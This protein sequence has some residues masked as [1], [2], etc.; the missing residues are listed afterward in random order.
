MQN[1]HI[2]MNYYTSTSLVTCRNMSFYNNPYYHSNKV[3][4]S[5]LGIWPYQSRLWSYVN[6]AITLFFICSLS[7]LEVIKDLLDG[8]KD[9]WDM[10]QTG[11]ENELLR[12]YAE[13]SRIF[14]KQYA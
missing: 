2:T 13:R 14:T 6:S 8:I 5:I 10:I 11:S 9:T 1:L 4:L 3:V 7:T 12:N